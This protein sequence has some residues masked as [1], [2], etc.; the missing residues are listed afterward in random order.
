VWEL[1]SRRRPYEGMH[2]GEI[3]GQVITQDLR[4]SPWPPGVP[5]EYVLVGT[6]CWAR[7]MRERP[8][9][10]NVLATL[11]ALLSMKLSDEQQQEA[12]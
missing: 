11:D 6:A 9:M 1:V 12:L 7:D 3:I 2:P 10:S 8:A 4:P 5:Q